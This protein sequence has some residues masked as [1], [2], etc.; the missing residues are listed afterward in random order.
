M[1][2][3]HWPAAAGWTAVA[4]ANGPGRAHLT[5]T[6]RGRITRQRCTRCPW[7]QAYH[8]TGLMSTGDRPQRQAASFIRPLSGVAALARTNPVLDEPRP[9]PGRR[10]EGTH[11]RRQAE[12]G[13]RRMTQDPSR[14]P[15]YAYLEAR[16]SVMPDHDRIGSAQRTRLY[17]GVGALTAPPSPTA[18][19]VLRVWLPGRSCSGAGSGCGHAGSY[20][21][22]TMTLPLACPSPR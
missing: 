4:V 6:I 3:D 2:A 14:D 15:S 19:R 13:Q 20:P 16:P 18:A 21:K 22:V 11:A 5:G 10:R 7:R 9:R 12:D 1:E 17:R 8:R